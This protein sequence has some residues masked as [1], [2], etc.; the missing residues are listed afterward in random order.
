M[1][2]TATAW[3]V[4]A[5]LLLVLSLRRAVWALALYF[6]TFFA[7]PH[8]WWWGSDIPSIRYALWSGVVLLVAVLFH[9]SKPQESAAPR[10][11]TYVHYAAIG[12]VVNATFVHLVLSVQ[13]GISIDTY[14]E[15]CKYVLL[16][17][18]I[19]RTLETRE[20]FRTALLTIAIGAAYIGWEVT[21]NDRGTFT[22]ARLEGVG[23]PSAETSNGLASLMLPVLP[24]IGSLFGGGTVIQKLIVAVAAPLALNVLLLCNS[25]GAFLGLIVSGVVFVAIARGATRKKAIQAL[26]FGVVALYLLLGDPK[27]LDRFLTTFAGSEERDNSA[28]GRLIYWSA[29]VQMLGDYPLGAG[30]GAF[31]HGLG[32][33]YTAQISEISEDRSVHNGY[34]TEAT[35]WG[36]Q[37]LTLKLIFVGGAIVAAYR[38]TRRCRLDG[39]SDDA[40]IGLCVIVSTTGFL[41]SCIFGSFLNSEWNFWLAAFLVRYSELYAVAEAPQPAAESLVFATPAKQ[42]G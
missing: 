23:A 17:F 13:P 27:I 25:R 15:L 11:L 26:A 6:M 7:A 18:L 3:V 4:L 2:L 40:L 8:L 21:V 9:T 14:I 30:G 12:M 31:K 19:G 33:R 41:V 28:N 5:V 35:D 39:R 29:A 34:L 20:D 32:S 42:A 36:V 1:T 24:L 37:G 22:G 38:T 10:R 16:F